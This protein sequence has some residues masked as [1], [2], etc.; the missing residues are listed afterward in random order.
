MST[1]VEY[2][3][4]PLGRIKLDGNDTHKFVFVAE[5]LDSLATLFRL[6]P[7]DEIEME[8]S[9]MSYGDF[10]RDYLGD[11][12]GFYPTLDKWLL[13]NYRA[14]TIEELER[15]GERVAIFGTKSR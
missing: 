5:D 6:N 1:W 13:K 10:K 15:T 12:Q 14:K 7:E 9:K 8:G 2:Q 11:I 4:K 3:G